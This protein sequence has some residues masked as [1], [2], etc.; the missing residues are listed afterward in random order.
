MESNYHNP[1]LFE[2]AIEQLKIKPNSIVIDMTLG[3]AGHSSE[4]LK[5]IPFGHLY[6]VDR[7]LDALK[8]SKEK[9]ERVGKNFTLIHSNFSNAPDVLESMGITGFDAM[10]YDL[11]VSSPQFDN[12]ERG[13][14]YR[15]DAPL[16]MR[17]NQEDRLSAEIVVNTYSY[18]ELRHVLCDYGEEKYGGLIAKAIVHQREIKPIHTTFDLVDVIKGCLPA[19]ALNRIGHPAKQSFLGIR[20]EVNKEKFEIEIGIARGI[21]ALNKGGRMAVITFNSLEDGLVKNIF[22]KFATTP[23]TDKYLPAQTID[24]EYTIITRKP[25]AP[26]S[27]EL[28]L[29]PRS[30]PAKMR[31]IERKTDDERKTY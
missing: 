13:F 2:E 20:Y 27:R 28:E 18:E 21:K 7:D 8:F 3:R 17:M 24:I 11:G 4:I 1:V 10:L 5:K 22:K 16:D 25:I 23:P 26:S 9:L 15:Y 12:P 30:K 31:V 14:S 6:G 19:K 29:N